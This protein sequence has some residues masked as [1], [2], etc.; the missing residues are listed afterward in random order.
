MLLLPPPLPP[1]PATNNPTPRRY[2]F[3]PPPLA[4]DKLPT[5]TLRH[6]DP[7]PPKTSAACS[8]HQELST[9]WRLRCPNCALMPGHCCCHCCYL[10]CFLVPSQISPSPPPL[11][12]LLLLRGL[13]LRVSLSPPNPRADRPP[14]YASFR[15]S[16]SLRFFFLLSL[17]ADASD[18]PSPPPSSFALL[19][20]IFTL[21]SSTFRLLS[22]SF[23]LPRFLRVFL[24]LLQG[25]AAASGAWKP[26]ANPR[27][28]LS[29][30]A[31]WVLVSFF[32]TVAS[33]AASPSPRRLPARGMSP[34]PGNESRRGD[35]AGTRHDRWPRVP[36]RLANFDGVA[37]SKVGEILMRVL[38]CL[39]RGEGS[40]DCWQGSKFDC[41]EM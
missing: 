18:S 36:R 29:L 25:V 8:Q 26:A 23:F 11:H 9:G 28:S 6:P 34:V 37:E 1:P 16:L 3:H 14:L 4:T 20:S 32:V 22:S 5:G 10:C 24:L 7:S 12:R 31:V 27:F 19:S 35:S 38:F 2:R 30:R 15:L 39:V 40:N 17:S 21:L 33:P 41:D 13:W